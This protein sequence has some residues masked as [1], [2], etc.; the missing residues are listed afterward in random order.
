MASFITDA[1]TQQTNSITSGSGFTTKT[2]PSLSLSSSSGLYYPSI[3][4]IRLYTNSI[5]ALTIDSN[6][7]LSGNG[8]GFTN[9]TSSQIP[10]LDVAKITSGTFGTSYIPSLDVAKI[11]SGTF[12]TSFIPSLDASKITTGTFGT[13]FIP[14]LD[15]SKI[16]TGTFATSFIPSLDAAKIATG[17]SIYH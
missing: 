8:S 16:T 6:G 9:F 2:K 3:N 4:N 11:T 14:S 10:S 15:A 7:V 17:T 1:S 12:A 13:S 5:D